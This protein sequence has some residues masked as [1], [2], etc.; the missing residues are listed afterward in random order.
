[1][2]FDTATLE[3]WLEEDIGFFD[4]TSHAL[5]VSST[6][7]RISW[8]VRHQ[9]VAACTEEV[10]RMLALQGAEVESV[11]PSGTILEAGDSLLSATGAAQSL[12]N[13]WKVG[14]NIFEFAC[15]VAHRAKQ[16]RQ[17][18]DAVNPQIGLFSTRKH[19]PGLRRLAQKAVMPVGVYPHR[20]GL[21]ETVLIFPQHRKLLAGGWDELK[22]ILNEQRRYL[23]EKKIIIEVNTKDEAL[24]AID[25]GADALQFDKVEPSALKSI[26]SELKESH[27]LPPDMTLLAAGGIRLDN[28][29]DYAA[30]GVDGLVTSSFYFGSPADIG[31]RIEL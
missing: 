13:C 7:A 20:L 1:M 3:A 25:C 19:P 26:I 4:L 9:T 6:P 16:M 8:V 22:A 12:L 31:V 27:Q 24:L 23:L 11:Q 2:F 14:Q 29:T 15:G 5:G 21:S 18:V 30:T 28:A 10:A 17:Q